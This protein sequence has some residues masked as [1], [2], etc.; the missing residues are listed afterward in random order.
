MT[1]LGER[2]G[3]F[4]GS[5]DLECLTFRVIHVQS[6]P[7]RADPNPAARIF[8]KTEDEVA[9]DGP[10]IVHVGAEDTERISVIPVQAVFRPEPEEA[11][12]VLKG[13]E[14]GALGEPLFDR[15]ASQTQRVGKARP[16]ERFRR[17]RKRSAG[18][19]DKGGEEQTEAEE[20]GFS[21]WPGRPSVRF[22][23]HFPNLS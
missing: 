16:A 3:G 20:Q 2:F 18:P 9:A 1:S 6:L 21:F 8:G 11:P 17:G 15:E 12:T 23:A 22:S 19:D 10:R 7:A 5:K 14:N 4:P 13:A